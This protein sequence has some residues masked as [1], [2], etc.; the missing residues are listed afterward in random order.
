[1]NIITQLSVQL[2]EGEVLICVSLLFQMQ[3]TRSSYSLWNP[4]RQRPHH[5]QR[6]CWKRLKRGN[7]S[8]KVAWLNA[9]LLLIYIFICTRGTTTTF[10][11]H[12]NATLPPRSIVVKLRA[13]ARGAGGRGSIPDRVTPKTLKVGLCAS[14][15]G[16][17]H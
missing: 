13:S 10:T 4:Q 1:M 14:Q 2:F 8:S 5:H 15:L 7:W 12:F 9:K 6:A 11:H 17:W 16:A 3:T